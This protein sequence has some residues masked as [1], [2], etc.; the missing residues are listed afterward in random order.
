[1][2]SKPSKQGALGPILGAAQQKT[3]LI[4]KNVIIAYSYLNRPFY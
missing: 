1:V 4:L 2:I 3:R